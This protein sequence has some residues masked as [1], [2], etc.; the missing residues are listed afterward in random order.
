M[1]AQGDQRPKHGYFRPS[2]AAEWERVISVDLRAVF[3][4]SQAVC[5]V[6]VAQQPRPGGSIVNISSVHSLACLPGAGP[7]DAAKWGVVG[8]GKSI[9]VELAAS[10]VRVNAL[11]PGLCNTMMWQVRVVML[12]STHMHKRARH[13]AFRVVQT[14]QWRCDRDSWRPRGRRRPPRART[15]VRARPGLLS[16]L[17]VSQS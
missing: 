12:Q 4:L 10:G 9:A 13:P 2:Q 16:I 11:S 15:T 7:Y 3:F 14:K 1:G 5:K 6:M 17:S 8:L